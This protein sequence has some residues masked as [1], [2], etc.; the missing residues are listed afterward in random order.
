MKRKKSQ[1]SE[2][3]GKDRWLVSYA[4]FITVLLAF[5]VVMYSASSIHNGK[6]EALTKVLHQTFPQTLE[7]L[8]ALSTKEATQFIESIENKSNVVIADLLGSVDAQAYSLMIKLNEEFKALISDKKIQLKN[9]EDW[10]EIEV[11]SNMLFKTGSSF[12]SN[13]AEF[14]IKKLAQILIVSTNT[15]TIEGFTDDIP[16]YNT[17]YPSN[18]ELS[19]DRASAVARAFIS[20]GIEAKRLAVTGYG[21]NFP[22]ADNKTEIGRQQ[23]RRIVIVVEKENKRKK[24]LAVLK[25]GDKE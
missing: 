13:D 2:R 3:A 17:I 22:I 7:N 12:L 23:N 21:E 4:D 19:T 10:L 5:F 9:S 16:I 1:H 24:Y 8:S 11:G 20:A 14:I 18:W 25:D 15:I 6:Y